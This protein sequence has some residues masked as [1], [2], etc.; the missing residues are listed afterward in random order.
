VNDP[1][2]Y[3]Q[4][5]TEQLAQENEVCR[6]IVKE[7]S[8]F[9]VTQRQVLMVIYLLASELENVEQ[10]RALTRI[11]RELGGDELFLIGKKPE[12]GD[13]DGTPDA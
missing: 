13:P 12:E 2:R 9:G 11:V 7:I 10:M 1:V 5:K 6:Q 3:S 4:S 8:N